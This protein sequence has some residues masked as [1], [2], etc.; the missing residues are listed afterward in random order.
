MLPAAHAH[1]ALKEQVARAMLEGPQRAGD[2]G[3]PHFEGVAGD[4]LPGG[5]TGSG[6]NSL[7]G[8]SV[9]LLPE[10]LF[11]KQSIR[12]PGLTRVMRKVTLASLFPHA[13]RFH[14]ENRVPRPAAQ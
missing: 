6:E 8:V 3:L 5:A 14:P 4:D 7:T 10:A 11:P 13:P 1:A 2:G 12:R 9:P